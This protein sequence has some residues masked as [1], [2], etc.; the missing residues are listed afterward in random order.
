MTSQSSKTLLE[1]VRDFYIGDA[2]LSFKIVASSI[3]LI[4][5]S[6]A[7][8]LLYAVLG[9]EDGNPLGLGL[10]FML[11]IFLGQ[12]GL[13]AGFLRMLWEFFTTRR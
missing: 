6:A 4:A 13:V 8:I 3:A 2:R 10:I 12:L 1:K 7:P 9:L 11:G 5:I